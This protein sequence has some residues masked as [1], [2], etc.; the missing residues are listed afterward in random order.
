M[1]QYF[2]TQSGDYFETMVEITPPTETAPQTGEEVELSWPDGRVPVPARPAPHWNWDSEAEV[3]VEGDQP[4]TPA[5]T[6]D[7][8]RF[9]Y[10][11]AFTGLDEVWE[12]L[13]A[14]LRETDR[15]A[16]ASLKAQRAKGACHLDVTL[17]LV[18]AYRSQAEQ[19]A[20]GADLSPEAITAAW[21]QAANA[22]I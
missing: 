4:E 22:E 17:G 9:E 5:P 16:Y 20:P 11:L 19:A 13:F 14:A 8:P 7:A 2:M 12:A 15:A 10:M 18:D 1:P 6:L 3:W 21:M